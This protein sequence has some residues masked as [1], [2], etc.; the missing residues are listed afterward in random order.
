MFSSFSQHRGEA[1]IRRGRNPVGYVP[2][3]G[4]AGDPSY[5]RGSLDELCS[6]SGPQFLPLHGEPRDCWAN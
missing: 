2:G 1:V 5:Q 3:G 4:G 6:P